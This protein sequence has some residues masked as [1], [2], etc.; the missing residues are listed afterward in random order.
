MAL[1]ICWELRL[2]L[3]RG[4]DPNAL[5]TN[6]NN[7]CHMMVILNK[8]E[9]F[10][11]AFELGADFRII[12][13]QGLSPL[14]VAAFLAHTDMFF[15][16]LNIERDI[17]WQVGQVVCAAYPLTVVDTIDVHT[18]ELNAKSALN[19]IVFGVRHMLLNSINY[20]EEPNL[21]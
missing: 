20:Y 16:I 18:G 21:L 3:A 8:M 12:N 17:Y 11:M 2:I 15:H 4:A 5:D 7:I 10:D 14:T 13:V 9:M 1:I 6:G 19:L